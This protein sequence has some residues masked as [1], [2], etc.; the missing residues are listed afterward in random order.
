M[1]EPKNSLKFVKDVNNFNISSNNGPIE[2][3]E[4]LL[5]LYN[6]HLCGMTAAVVVSDLFMSALIH[7]NLFNC[8]QYMPPPS[9]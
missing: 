4:G 7:A 1:W 8:Q 9:H 6:L 2:L 5:D 3:G